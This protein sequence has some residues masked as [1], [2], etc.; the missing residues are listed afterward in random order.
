MTSNP[1]TPEPW[2]TITQYGRADMTLSPVLRECYKVACLIERCGASPELTAA[3][4]AAFDLCEKVFDQLMQLCDAG[5]RDEQ[6]AKRLAVENRELRAQLSVETSAPTGY[7]VEEMVG[8]HWQR[9]ALGHTWE[10]EDDAR[11]QLED[12][13]RRFGGKAFRL[14]TPDE[15]TAPMACENCGSISNN[16]HHACC[17]ERKMIPASELIRSLWKLAYP[18]AETPAPRFPRAWGCHKENGWTIDVG[19][20]E[21]LRTWI[22]EQPDHFGASDEAIEEVLLAIEAIDRGSP[23]DANGFPVKASGES[24][25][26]IMKEP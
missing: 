16:I 4:S 10:R 13:R 15:T 25:G 20:I 2:E 23:L 14:H 12:L 24:S 11:R 22:K 18:P 9:S 7:Y 26:K 3:S 21:R 19:Y 5:I 1:M 6:E 17:P 8:G